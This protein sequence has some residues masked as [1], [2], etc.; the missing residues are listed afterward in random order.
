MRP[1][2]L[3]GAVFASRSK[4]HILRAIVRFA[5]GTAEPVCVAAGIVCS[6]ALMQQYVVGPAGADNQIL[7]SVIR[8]DLVPVMNLRA[9]WQRLPEATFSDNYMLQHCFLFVRNSP[10]TSWISVPASVRMASRH[11]YK[12]MVSNSSQVRGRTH[13]QSSESPD[14]CHT[15]EMR[16]QPSP[17]FPRTGNN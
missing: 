17:Y 11:S 9:F 4:L 14:R 5:V 1:L 8:L 2:K 16:H 3:A 7:R 6:G 10:V 12:L 13:R 15:N